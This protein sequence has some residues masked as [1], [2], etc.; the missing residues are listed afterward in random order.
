MDIIGQQNFSYCQR[1][2]CKT[3]FFKA[4]ISEEGNFFKC[5][6]CILEDNQNKNYLFID[7]IL[8]SKEEYIFKNLPLFCN[9]TLINE[10]DQLL[11]N[12][13]EPIQLIEEGFN[14]FR[15][16]MV[17]II[18]QKKKVV[19]T[20]LQ[21]YKVE[22]QEIFNIYNQLSG[23]AYLKQVLSQNE[24][25]EKKN[26]ELQV[27]L[28]KQ[29][30]QKEQTDF[31][32]H[33]L[34]K[35]M[36]IY[37]D[38]AS[39]FN[40]QL[41]QKDFIQKLNNLD[42]KINEFNTQSEQISQQYL[43]LQNNLME[44]QNTKINNSNQL[45]NEQHVDFESSKNNKLNLN[46]L[47]SELSSKNQLKLLQGKEQFADYQ[48]SKDIY[49][50][51]LQHE[52]I[53]SISKNQK[54]NYGYVYFKYEL[55]KSK[56]YKIRIKFNDKGGA[57]IIIGLVDSKILTYHLNQSKQGKCFCLDDN[58]YGGKVSKGNYFSDIYQNMVIEMRVDIEQMQIQFL[59]FPQYEHINQLQ[60]EFLLNP[61]SS[62]YLTF[63]FGLQQ[64]CPQPYET[65]VDIIYFEETE[66]F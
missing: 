50:N 11:Q 48:Q 8:N 25:Q 21:N 63:H 14:N 66:S 58:K 62:Y 40:L 24:N 1:H 4:S 28:R 59:D 57:Y 41:I 42:L 16:E 30:Q 36:K 34:V 18:D 20:C 65:M 47:F 32:L 22:K 39:I 51:Y 56:K 60:N 53:I 54:V 31:S 29:Y 45:I 7:S 33:L 43:N 55:D 19:L 49:V 52:N 15:N 5:G 2:S 26:S 64:S 44:K 27:Y 13:K 35:K 61:D 46:D 17:S 23:K 10:L 6:Q 3:H 9:Q 37:F 12:F 38:T